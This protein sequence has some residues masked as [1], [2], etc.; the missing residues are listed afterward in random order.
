V[1]FVVQEKIIFYFCPDLL[2][3]LGGLATGFYIIENQKDIGSMLVVVNLV[4][5]IAT[6]KSQSSAT[7][8]KAFSNLIHRT[9]DHSSKCL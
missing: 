7:N 5:L 2:F 8:N 1:A 4:S 6:C 3:L 9:R